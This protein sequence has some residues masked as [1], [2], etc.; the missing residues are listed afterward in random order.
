MNSMKNW[1][2]Y[3]DLNVVLTGICEVFD[4]RAEMAV[5]IGQNN[6]KALSGETNLP[7]IK[8]YKHY[9]DLLTS[10]DIDAVIIATPDFW[11]TKMSI[12]AINAGKHVYCEKAPTRT[13]EEAYQLAAAL[14]TFN[15]N[16]AG[17]A[18]VIQKTIEFLGYEAVY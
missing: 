14:K 13:E 17:F 1:M 5:E 9:H 6:V 4:E 18:I 8:R 15:I 2:R 12:D 7:E 11:H 3:K 16:V 10:N